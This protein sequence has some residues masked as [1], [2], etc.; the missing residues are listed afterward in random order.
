MKAITYSEYGAPEVLHVRDVSKPVPKVDEVLV[1]VIA[2]EATKSDCELRSFNF[3]IKWFWLP[4]RIALG[5][6]R[7][8]RQILGGYFSGIVESIGANVSGFS[9]GDAVFGT[10]GLRLG[11]YGE[12]VALPAASTLLA[13]PTKMSFAD[14]AAVPLGGLNALHFMRLADIR[15][16]ERILII[17]AGGSIGLYAVQIAKSMG[18]EV[19]AVDSTIKQE[20][21]QQ[22]GA[23][24]VIDYSRENFA[25]SGQTYDVIF[26]MV[27]QTSYAACMK[28]LTPNGRY[29]SGNP[30][31]SI[32]LRSIWTTRF[33]G[34][35]ASFAFA[36]E[37]RAELDALRKMIEDGRIR[38]IVD[39]VYPMEQAAD[40][41]RR[42]ET[43]QRIGAVV[44]AIGDGAAQ[45]N[46]G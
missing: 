45:V 42:V 22:M 31:L 1:R 11:A 3:A 16:G 23:D 43:E 27:P 33:T 18:A 6:R 13:K 30:R 15:P 46:A 26:D 14:A 24:H 12:Y 36:R 34:K 25:D 17:G 37:T 20:L 32:M 44:I 8:R 10:T 38:S 28:S 5:M 40:A 21:L 39:R 19:S 2:T 9:V 7:P 4:L 29:L 35:W 41:H